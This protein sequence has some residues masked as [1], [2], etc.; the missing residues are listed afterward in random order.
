MMSEQ[1]QN[2]FESFWRIHSVQSPMRHELIRYDDL[3]TILR[4]EANN[5]FV[6]LTTVSR[7]DAKK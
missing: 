4:R 5:S 7:G 6:N 1:Q 2:S 3:L